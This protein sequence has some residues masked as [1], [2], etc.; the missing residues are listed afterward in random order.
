[1]ALRWSLCSASERGTYN[2]GFID[3]FEN[4]RRILCTETCYTIPILILIYA[5]GSHEQMAVLLLLTSDQ[6]IN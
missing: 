1:M 5:H 6:L 3:E 4:K 2:I